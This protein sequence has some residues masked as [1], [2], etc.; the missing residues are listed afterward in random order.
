MLSEYTRTDSLQRCSE[1]ATHLDKTLEG[2][3]NITDYESFGTYVHESALDLCTTWRSRMGTEIGYGRSTKLLN[4]VLKKL[5]CLKNIDDN[6]RERIVGFQHV[7]L[8]SYTIVGLRV[9]I[10]S[11][12]IP[13]NASMKFIERPSEYRIV[14]KYIVDVATEAGVPP[15]YYD[16]LAWD[17]AHPSA[18]NGLQRIANKVGSR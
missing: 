13:R 7:P 11:L 8:D 1:N 10:T 2:L 18:N 9:L 6:V 17:M 4:L 3:K 16:I 15:I 5:A 12:K 14:Q